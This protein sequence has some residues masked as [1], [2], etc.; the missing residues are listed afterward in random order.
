MH[1][2]ETL[3]RYKALPSIDDLHNLETDLEWEDFCDWYADRSQQLAAI[4]AEYFDFIED[5]REKEGRLFFR[6][7]T[8]VMPSQAEEGLDSAF[9]LSESDQNDAAKA[10]SESNAEEAN[11]V[12][13]GEGSVH[14]L[15]GLTGR[16]Y[17]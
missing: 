5:Q 10:N 17:S 7:C 4:E 16:S 9:P 1:N 12:N 14:N 15:N 13:A 6:W 11:G 3:L 2:I 8:A